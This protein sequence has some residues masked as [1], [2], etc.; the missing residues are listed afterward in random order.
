MLS[1]TKNS[2]S[3]KWF[4]IAIAY[5]LFL[6]A[7]THIPQERMPE[8]LGLFGID[9]ILHIVA[10]AILTVLFMR[11]VGTGRLLLY[12]IVTVA[13][14]LGIAAIDE[15]TQR[16]VSRT[17]SVYDWLADVVGISLALFCIKYLKGRKCQRS[18][19]PN[20]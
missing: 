7:A 9:K 13:V 18:V 3:A 10:Y 11:A 5:C 8:S 1:T 16:Y 19:A 12:Y 15:Y 4:I 17:C 14:I 6:M 2:T 20:L